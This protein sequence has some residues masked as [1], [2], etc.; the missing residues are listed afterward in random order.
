MMNETLSRSPFTVLFFPTTRSVTDIINKDW[1]GNTPDTAHPCTESNPQPPWYLYPGHWYLGGILKLLQNC[2]LLIYK[3][4]IKTATQSADYG[5]SL[6][7]RPTIFPIYCLSTSQWHPTWNMKVKQGKCGCPLHHHPLTWVW[8]PQYKHATF[9]PL[10]HLLHGRRLQFRTKRKLAAITPLLNKNKWLVTG[11]GISNPDLVRVARI[12]FST[13]IT[14]TYTH[15]CTCTCIY[16]RNHP[17]FPNPVPLDI[18]RVLSIYPRMSIGSPMDILYLYVLYCLLC[19]QI[20]NCVA[21]LRGLAFAMTIWTGSLELPVMF[22]VVLRESV[23][24][25]IMNIITGYNITVHPGVRDIGLTNPK[26]EYIS[27]HTTHTPIPS[28]HT[29]ILLQYVSPSDFFAEL[30]VFIYHIL[31]DFKCYFRTS[32]HLY[33]VSRLKCSVIRLLP[34]IGRQRAEY[35]TSFPSVGQVLSN[36]TWSMVFYL[37]RVHIYWYMYWRKRVEKKKKAIII[38]IIRLDT[39]P[40]IHYIDRL[41]QDVHLKTIPTSWVIG[42]DIKTAHRQ[43][44]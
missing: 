37:L 11:S 43:Q 30:A 25:I 32:T 15:V 23:C 44:R 40:M 34:S 19:A 8:H 42:R 13:S 27:E 41:G 18:R 33:G 36:A 39:R 20:L 5:C 3:Y 12:V 9:T 10:P 16:T 17:R 31:H 24:V 2:V 29:G 4:D 21:S 38:T 6:G 7:S 1:E 35:Q 26:H 22:E 28:I 14:Y